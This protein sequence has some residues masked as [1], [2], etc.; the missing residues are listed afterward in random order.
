MEKYTIEDVK[1]LQKTF[2]EQLQEY[3]KYSIGEKKIP[4]KVLSK[5]KKELIKP[6]HER[7]KS[8]E[9]A[10]T[11]TIKK[12]DEEIAKIKKTVAQIEKEITEGQKKDSKQ[13]HEKGGIIKSKTEKN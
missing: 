13:V 5:E 7:I 10:K 12:M 4:S 8:M 3:E 2:I 1:K 9:K 6:Y 11:E